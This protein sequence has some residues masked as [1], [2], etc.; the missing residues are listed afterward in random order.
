MTG[1]KKPFKDHW[2]SLIGRMERL[3]KKDTPG[4]HDYW[5][6]ACILRRAAG[7][8]YSDTPASGWREDGTPEIFLI[9]CTIVESAAV[10]PKWDRPESISDELYKLR[11][12]FRDLKRQLL[13]IDKQA[14]NIINTHSDPL[15]QQLVYKINRNAY[16]SEEL[17]LLDK[18]IQEKLDSPDHQTPIEVALEQMDRIEEGLTRTLEEVEEHARDR[19]DMG[20]PRTY[21]AKQVAF[22]VARYMYQVNGKIPGLWTGDHPSGP[23]ANAVLE[24]FDILK[25]PS[26]SFQRAGEYAIK[27]LKEDHTAKLESD[28]EF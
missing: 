25:I 2:L 23:Y 22:G 21:A 3:V 26:R 4:L 15:W 14:I 19:K 20:Q 12:S 17:D 24:I 5:Q 11:Y 18:E 10:G 6:I 28:A 1:E 7:L 13:S 27:K 16:S 8:P 9:V